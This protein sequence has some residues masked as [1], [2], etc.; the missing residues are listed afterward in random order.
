MHDQ[1]QITFASL[2]ISSVY[3]TTHS[4]FFPEKQITERFHKCCLMQSQ[5]APQI[6]KAPLIPTTKSPANKKKGKTTPQ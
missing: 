5:K 1:T 4:L 6:P 3:L 2:M